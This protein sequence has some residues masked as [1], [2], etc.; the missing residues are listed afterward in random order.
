ML[1]AVWVNRRLPLRS[2][3]RMSYFTP[4]VLPMIAVANIWLFF[5]TPDIG[6]I[7]QVTGVLR[8][9][10]P[11]TGSAIRTRCSAASSS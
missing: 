1:M 10:A 2:F 9:P 11:T 3:V 8:N 4:T 5:Y 7:D 6:L